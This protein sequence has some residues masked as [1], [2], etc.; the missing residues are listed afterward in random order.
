MIHENSRKRKIILEGIFAMKCPDDFARGES[1][2][3]ER[4]YTTRIEPLSMALF[5]GVPPKKSVGQSVSMGAPSSIV[6]DSLIPER[7]ERKRWG[8]HR[9]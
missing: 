2:V 3:F 9:W 4:I 8:T 7:R 5:R 6:G 1:H